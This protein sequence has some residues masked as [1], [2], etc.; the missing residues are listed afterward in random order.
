MFAVSFIAGARRHDDENAGR[1]RSCA[2]FTGRCARAHALA[3]DLNVNIETHACVSLE[4]AES[5]SRTG[6]G[7]RVTHTRPEN[8][9]RLVYTRRAELTYS[10]DERIGL[11]CGLK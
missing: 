7:Y 8:G 9:T 1:S 11:A 6:T 5:F 10:P 4:S 2:V 3:H